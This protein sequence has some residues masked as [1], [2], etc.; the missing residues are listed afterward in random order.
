VSI[1]LLLLATLALAACH[2]SPPVSPSQPTGALKLDSRPTG[3][4][5]LVDGKPAGRTPVDLTLTAGS[6]E[7]EVALVKRT[8]LIQAGDQGSLRLHLDTPRPKDLAEVEGISMEEDTFN[9]GKPW[10]LSV[11]VRIAD[12]PRL[13]A[14]L[15]A[16]GIARD[17]AYETFGD[18]PMKRLEVHIGHLVPVEL[19]KAVLELYAVPSGLSVYVGIDYDESGFLNER[20]IYVGSFVQ[21]VEK[22]TSREDL[23]SLS[24][25]GATKEEILQRLPRVPRDEDEDEDEDEE[26]ED[27]ILGG[28]GSD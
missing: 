12:L 14:R 19:I 20:R 28:E 13:R 26:D 22:R 1:R 9:G 5:V 25:P 17:V 3:V 23:R 24:R 8:V 21:T 4:L 6:H 11:W 16:D 27:E 15:V 2:P 10:A 7:L 18:E